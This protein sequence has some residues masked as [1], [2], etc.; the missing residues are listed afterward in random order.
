MQNW[1][2]LLF[3]KPNSCGGDLGAS[4]PQLFGRGGDRPHRPHGVGAYDSLLLL[5]YV[6]LYPCTYIWQMQ[7]FDE[8]AAKSGDVYDEWQS[9]KSTFL[10]T[11]CTHLIIAVVTDVAS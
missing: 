8:K 3:Q 9:T 11:D 4:P 10:R 5:N 2:I 7:A 6:T 1:L